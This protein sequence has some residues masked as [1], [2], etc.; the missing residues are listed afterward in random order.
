[1][2]RIAMSPSTPDSPRDPDDL[3]RLADDLRRDIAWLRA[4]VHA[5]ALMIEK[6]RAQLAVLRRARF[7]RKS[8]K[9]DAQV[10]QLELLIDDIEAG[11]AETLARAGVVE[12]DAAEATETGASSKKKRKPSNRAPL[13][14]HLPA[15][16]IVH[17]A[18]CVCPACGGDKFGRI[19]AD[20]REVLEY[21]PSHFKR[22][23]HVRPK[24]SCRACET[25]VQAPMPTLPIEKGRPGPALL[26]HVV[27]SKFCDHLPL[28]RQANI[29]ARSGVEID[30]SVMAGWIGRLAGLLEPLSERIE[31][32]VRAG[33]AL[34][35]D[36]T[37]VPVLDPG[38]GKT[39]TGRL[40]TVVRDERPFGATP[41]P[42]AFYRYSPDRKAEHAQAL[43]AGCRGSLHADGYAGFA[44]LYKPEPETG[45]PRLTEVA[46]W[47]HARRK[48]YDVLVE[49]GSP[50]AREALERSAR[51]FAVEAD[52]RGRSPAERRE[53][54]QRRSAPI[55]VDLR[56]F[57]DATLA[58][59]SGKSSLAGAIRY[60]TSRWAALTRFVDDGRLEM[61]NNAAERA[62]RP[63][64]LGRKNY[65]F[66]GSDEGGRR[67]AIMYT[68]I[69][70]A[71]LN[72][73][74]PEAWLAD[75]I[76]RIAD[77][78]INRVDKLLPW[79]WS[80]IP[81]QAKAA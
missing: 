49:T 30:R 46:C 41:P 7:G 66:A 32:H 55:L 72:G 60:A 33:L 57:L 40:W 51:L 81:A 59:I 8:E 29:Y 38:K 37:P 31:R 39:K 53:A 52:I 6:L 77:H 12:S 4:E 10:E 18:P 75:V 24:M 70:T 69:E 58:K 28:N 9:L 3:R 67:A 78:P 45:V 64:A 13:P 76:A 73:V 54:R 61:T 34:H 23:V 20:E 63:L 1:V 43:L 21:V 50:A 19:G 62:I 15:E 27:V 79:N 48:I 65:L 80:P 25:V 36:D 16:T 71:R 5:K 22:V 2:V 68:L 47:A 17:E 42:A 74:D 26:A 35:A 14:D 44:D 11:V 56:A